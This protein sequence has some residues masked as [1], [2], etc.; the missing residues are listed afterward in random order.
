MAGAG[1]RL[2]MVGDDDDQVAPTA[3]GRGVPTEVS[4]RRESGCGGV[5]T[6][7]TQ[8][9]AGIW[10]CA[11]RPNVEGCHHQ[12]TGAGWH[13]APDAAHEG[14]DMS[15]DTARWT[16]ANEEAQAGTRVAN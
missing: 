8:G 1:N 6:T 9:N 10:R 15:D 2:R 14:A 4:V 16:Q 11:V 3:G 12:D 5:S 7:T 13:T